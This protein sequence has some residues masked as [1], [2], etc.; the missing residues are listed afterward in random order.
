MFAR[1]FSPWYNSEEGSSLFFETASRRAPPCYLF[2]S[3]EGIEDRETGGAGNLPPPEAVG[4]KEGEAA[5]PFTLRFTSATAPSQGAY[6]RLASADTFLG[7]HKAGP[8]ALESL[9]SPGDQLAGNNTAAPGRLSS[10]LRMG[11]FG[12]R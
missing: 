4:Y 3:Q 5:G 11:L 10:P 9:H 6:Y 2:E 12:V 7:L 1:C 8:T